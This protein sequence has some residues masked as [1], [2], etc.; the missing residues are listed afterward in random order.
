MDA[1]TSFFT[2]HLETLG[3]LAY[4]LVFVIS[5]LESLAFVG[6][7]IPGSTVLIGAGALAALHTLRFGNLVLVAAL[8]GILGDVA[9]FMLGRFGTKWFSKESKIFKDAYLER[10]KVFFQKHGVK[11][12][13]L[14]RF[15]GPLRPVIPFVAGLTN[16]Q[17]RS[18]LVSNVVGGILA[19]IVYVGVGFVSGE[20][21]DRVRPFIRVVKLPVIVLVLVLGALL[22][23]WKYLLKR[24]QSAA[25][26]VREL[27]AE[28]TGALMENPRVE[29]FL[30]RHE[31]MEK[32]MVSGQTTYVISLLG[33]FVLTIGT[34]III[35]SHQLI[36]FLQTFWLAELDR[37]GQEA[38]L[39]L[40]S[41]E[42]TLF[43]KLTTML[44]KSYVVVGIGLVACLGIWKKYGRVWSISFAAT[45]A[46]SGI[47]TYVFKYLGERPRPSGPALASEHTFSFPSGHAVFAVVLYG[48]I[49]YILG[50]RQTWANKLNIWMVTLVMIVV[51]GMSR[52]YL[53]VHYM[54]D[55]VFG[56]WFG[57]AW[58]V[59]GVKIGKMLEQRKKSE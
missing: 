30:E 1:I 37:W 44:G 50:R 6:L 9:S 15:I 4:A 58:L 31:R 27:K 33:T 5:F 3:S 32:I 13:L 23:V 7:L 25:Q 48:F 41:D 42:L 36:P 53:G 22:I 24:G 57:A 49:A 20:A 14:A 40:R 51:I 2:I 29:A 46:V 45:L 26:A 38:A 54:T 55:V 10:G 18:F 59:S 16:M 34:L 52:V 43:F 17:W 19:A 35:L 12:I 39:I 28:T 11:S 8:G 47:G 21:F 56:Y